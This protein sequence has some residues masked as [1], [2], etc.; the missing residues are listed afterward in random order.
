MLGPHRYDDRLLPQTRSA[1][2]AGEARQDRPGTCPSKQMGHAYKGQTL[3]LSSEEEAGVATGPQQGR[4]RKAG[5]G[6]TVV[7]ADYPSSHQVPEAVQRGVPS[8]FAAAR[9]A[10]R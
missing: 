4:A 9:P 1:T 3:S 2:A 6:L 10:G 7:P 8:I 5:A